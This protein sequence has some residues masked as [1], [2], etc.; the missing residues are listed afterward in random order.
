MLLDGVE[1]FVGVF[2]I[3]VT[4]R[5]D[6]VDLVFLRLGRFDYL[7]Y[8]LMLDVIVCVKIVWIFMCEIKVVLGVD[9]VVIV[10]LECMESFLGVDLVAFVSECVNVVA[11][12]VFKM[13]IVV[14]ECGE[15]V[16]ELNVL[17][18]IELYDV[19]EVLKCLCVL[20]L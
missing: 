12:W 20:L 13:Y 5:L 1:L 14:V 2:V 17:L 10:E 8:L 19:V 16:V 7:L 4:S 15:D 18:M 11:T 6:V 9:L 3:C